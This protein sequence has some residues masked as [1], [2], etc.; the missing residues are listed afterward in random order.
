MD[1]FQIKIGYQ[2]LKP[3]YIMFYPGAKQKGD[4]S[5]M[6]GDILVIIFLWKG[7]KK[8]V[9]LRKEPVFITIRYCQ[10]ISLLESPSNLF[11]QL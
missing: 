4:A 11:I 1:L 9:F 7:F 3:K 6:S 10:I 8:K 2:S 5:V